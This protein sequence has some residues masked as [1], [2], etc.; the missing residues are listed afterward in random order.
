MD[1][2][3]CSYFI[4]NLWRKLSDN[5]YSIWDVMS[6]GRLYLNSIVVHTASRHYTTFLYMLTLFLTKRVWRPEYGYATN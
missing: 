6:Y 1:Q 3:D 4:I 5:L 2:Q